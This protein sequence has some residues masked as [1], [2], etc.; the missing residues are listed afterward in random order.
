MQIIVDVFHRDGSFHTYDSNSTEATWDDIIRRQTHKHRASCKRKRGDQIVCRFIIPFLPMDVTRV[1][2]PFNADEEE[3]MTEQELAD[4]R[5][6][7]KR[8]R[9][10]LDLN[11]VALVDSVTTFDEFL[12]AIEIS[13]VDAYIDSIRSTLKITKVILRRTPNQVLTNSYNRK[14]LNAETSEAEAENLE[15]NDGGDETEDDDGESVSELSQQPVV[16]SG[17]SGRSYQ[18]RAGNPQMWITRRRKFKV[19]RYYK[20][21]KYDE[22]R[23]DYFRTLLIMLY[24]KPQDG[25]RKPLRVWVDFRRGESC[26]AELR[27]SQA[28]IIRNLSIAHAWKMIEPVSDYVYRNTKVRLKIRRKQFPLL[29]AESLTVHKSQGQTYG[30]VTIIDAVASGSR[31]DRQ[32]MYVA[33]TRATASSGL[34]I[35]ASNNTF[36][37]FQPL[38]RSNPTSPLRMELA[39]QETDETIVPRFLSMTTSSYPDSILVLSHNIIQSLRAHLDQVSSDLVYNSAS[40]LLFSETWTVHNSPE[41]FQLPGFELVSRS[42]NVQRAAPSAAGASC[43]YVNE[44]MLGQRE[45]MTTDLIFRV[46]GSR[47]ISVALVN[48]NSKLFASVYTSPNAPI[49]LIMESL[50]FIVQ[51][52]RTSLFIGGDFNVDFGPN[53]ADVAAKKSEILSFM[54]AKQLHSLFENISTSQNGIFIDNVFTNA[55]VARSEIPNLQV[56]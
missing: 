14:I 24:S 32:L 42:D 33:C 1:S 31:L 45:S 52:P 7:Y 54:T 27:A 9:Q 19:I 20:F 3:I 25:S 35:V 38:S 56:V 2:R 21:N 30:S 8:I 23:P 26:G 55:Q 44:N 36:N 5:Y 18:M 43:S 10:Y 11:A 51:H 37:T 49:A 53:A 47:S 15:S 41:A 17:V 46:E 12:Q 13:S 28:S 22:T 29:S 34:R 4:I 40:V 48:V 50:R 16:D 6:R 39:R